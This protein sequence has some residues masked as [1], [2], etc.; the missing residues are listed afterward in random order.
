MLFQTLFLPFAYSGPGRHPPYFCILNCDLELNLSL[1]PL[2]NCPLHSHP[3]LKTL[4][5][6]PEPNCISS[7]PYLP[8]TSEFRAMAPVLT[9]AHSYK[10]TQFYLFFFFSL[11]PSRPFGPP[12]CFF[13]GALSMEVAHADTQRWC[14]V[15]VWSQ[16]WM[17]N[18][19]KSQV[20]LSRQWL[21]FMNPMWAFW[22]VC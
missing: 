13:V 1:C 2:L 16:T 4:F 12:L 9:V 7:V 20:G 17:A 21:S 19:L 10:H 6:T 3:S 8:L 22:L 5:P 11:H 14:R 15:H 18:H